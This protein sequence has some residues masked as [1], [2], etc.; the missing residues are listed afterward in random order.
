MQKEGNGFT[1]FGVTLASTSSPVNGKRSAHFTSNHWI[2]TTT[3]IVIEL[4]G[5]MLY[6]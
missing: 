4:L 2:S 3:G 1:L 5:M 6:H